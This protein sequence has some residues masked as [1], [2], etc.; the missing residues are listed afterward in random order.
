M[1]QKVC[2]TEHLKILGHRV[3]DAI[4][5]FEGVAESVCFDL[6]GCI[7]VAVKPGTDKE[8]KPVDGHWFDIKRLKVESKK[9]VVAPPEF[10]ATAQDTFGPASKPAFRS[11]PIR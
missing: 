8:G 3:K 1:T 2:V 11:S 6:Y 10:T 7:Q 5:G 9:V 4:T